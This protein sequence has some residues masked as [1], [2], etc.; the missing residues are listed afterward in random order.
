M[1]AL[2]LLTAILG[3]GCAGQ[4]TDPRAA[5]S[6]GP[7]ALT[8]A[9]RLQV[10]K[11]HNLKIVDKDGQQLFCRSNFV[12]AS[13]IRQDTTCYTADELDQMEA[14]TTRDL[15]RLSRASSIGGIR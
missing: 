13:R 14:Q 3:A 4:A 9:Q 12:T 11:N 6:A 5:S 10:A 7:L 2:L 1:R 8:D 15:D